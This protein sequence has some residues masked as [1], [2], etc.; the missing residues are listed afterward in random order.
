M[1]TLLLSF[2]MLFLFFVSWSYPTIPLDSLEKRLN[3]LEMELK[4]L[5]NEPYNLNE[6]VLIQNLQGNTTKKLKIIKNKETRNKGI[7]Q[8]SLS[9]KI[10]ILSPLFAV[11]ITI[12]LLFIFLKQAGFCLSE[13][14]SF[15]HIDPDPEGEIIY[16]PSASKLIAFITII[17]GSIFLSFMFT[18]YLYFTFKQLPTPNFL[19][20]WPTAIFLFIGILPYI[21]QT[22]FKKTD[23]NYWKYKLDELKNSNDDDDEDED[24]ELY[25]EKYL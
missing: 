24:E 16:Y 5:K 9:Q 12:L 7:R 14:L 3:T 1:K 15:K 17:L 11:F 2:S 22:I 21:F 25:Y 20:L 6:D 18:F 13:A 10:F 4:V 23:E 8:L 19:S